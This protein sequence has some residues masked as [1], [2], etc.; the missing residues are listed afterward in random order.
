M[1]VIFVIGWKPGFNKIEMSRLLRQ[2]LGYS[3][4]EAKKFVDNI[5]GGQEVEF[6]VDSEVFDQLVTEFNGLGAILRIGS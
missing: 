3:L 5:V 6:L 1:S 2:R 4:G